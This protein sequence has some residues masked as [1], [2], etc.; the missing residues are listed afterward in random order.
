MYKFRREQLEAFQQHRVDAYKQKFIKDIIDEYPEAK[1]SISQEKIDEYV[2]KSVDK[3]LELGITSEG[4][5][6]KFV[7]LVFEL[8]ALFFEDPEYSWL[9]K[10][11]NSS[12]I[13]GDKKVR[14]LWGTV[15][16]IETP[17]QESD[18]YSK[19]LVM[20]PPEE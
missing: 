2:Q 10:I 12:V 14:A 6:K 4:A 5:V 9:N 20:G 17:F 11:L 1:L 3:A 18:P 13:D 8:E 19:T 15:L 7:E 16:S